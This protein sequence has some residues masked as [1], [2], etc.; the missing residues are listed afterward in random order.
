MTNDIF[1]FATVNLDRKADGPGFDKVVDDLAED[2]QMRIE[3][4]KACLIKLGLRVNQEKVPVPSLSRLHLSS[5]QP[6]AMTAL[7][8]SLDDVIVVDGDEEYLR[9]ENDTFQF[10]RSSTGS[11]G[12]S[13]NTSHGE[14]SKKTDE[15]T[16]SSDAILD[17]NAVTKQ[18]LVHEREYPAC[19]ETPYFN[20]HAFFSNL[21]HYQS[22]TDVSGEFGRCL[23]YGEVVTSTNTMLE[24]FASTVVDL[25][26][27]RI[28]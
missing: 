10:Q 24:K 27:F 23:L 9:G 5:L 28:S 18:V 2:D 12:V 19:K 6:F 16:M 20:H 21:K 1:R 26:L 14:G 4:L 7:L 11:M 8:D 15:E 3:F 17:Y 25:W 22:L 13:G